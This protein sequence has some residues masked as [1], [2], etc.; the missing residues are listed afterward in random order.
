MGYTFEELITK[1]KKKVE[2]LN[3]NEEKT[4]F[5]PP[6][7]D[8]SFDLEVLKKDIELYLPGD[9]KNYW[10]E[11]ASYNPNFL[12]IVLEVFK[13]CHNN[14]HFSE[15]GV[16][17]FPNIV[18]W[19]STRDLAKERYK[20]LKDKFGKYV[21]MAAMKESKSDLIVDDIVFPLQNRYRLLT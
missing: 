16:G 8:E 18:E 3:A 17:Y 19:F 14:N 1:E 6:D 12:K 15:I 20:K 11:R 4:K 21:Y 9:L 13:D 2:E 10:L 5:K 7:I